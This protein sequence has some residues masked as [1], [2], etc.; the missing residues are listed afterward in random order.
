MAHDFSGQGALVTGAGTGIGQ[1]VANALADAG[2]IVTLVGRRTDVLE[3]A[4][5]EIKARGKQALSAAADVSDPEA[6][7]R[8]A[9]IADKAPKGLSILVTCAAGPAA[10]G[11]SESLT[12]ESWK[13]IIDTDLTGSF[14]ACQAAGRRMLARKYGRIVNLASFHVIATYPQRAAYVAA[15]A[16]VVGLTQALAVEWGGRGII[17]NAVAP[18][19]IRTPRTSWFLSQDPANEEGMIGRTP[20]GRI[21]ELADVVDPILFLASDDARHV[22]GQTIVVDGAWTK[23]AW[24]GRHPFGKEAKP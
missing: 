16:G 9:A 6:L 10:S 8:A 11:P 24:W 15:K 19:P 1:A 3:K 13:G 23:N 7:D 20:T 12:A 18:G 17:V 5:A 4:L 22:S 2:A 14:Y 21:G